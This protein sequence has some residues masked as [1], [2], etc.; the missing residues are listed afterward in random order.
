MLLD[1]AAGHGQ[2]ERLRRTEDAVDDD[3]DGGAEGAGEE[4]DVR[5]LRDVLAVDREDSVSDEEAM[6]LLSRH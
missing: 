1:A 3:V 4:I 2:R 6:A 5:Y